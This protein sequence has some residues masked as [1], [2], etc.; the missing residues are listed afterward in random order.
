[1]LNSH[2][3][4]KICFGDLVKLGKLPSPS[5]GATIKHAHFCYLPDKIGDF[6]NFF[7]DFCM[8]CSLA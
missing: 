4:E 1:M 5:I 6:S 2:V 8:N 3:E 7:L